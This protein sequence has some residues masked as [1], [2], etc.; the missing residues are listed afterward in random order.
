M[1]DKVELRK[2]TI[3]EAVTRIL[4][5][6]RQGKYKIAF[7]MG[8]DSSHDGSQDDWAGATWDKSV[9]LM[10]NGWREGV[11]K[12]D[13][14]ARSKLAESLRP[15]PVWDVAGSDCDVAAYLAG[16]PECMG[17]IVRRR[18]PT[19]VV[20]IGVDRCASAY[21]RRDAI[22]RV[23]QNV[24]VLVESLRLAGSAAE[25][26]ACQ[27]VA[28]SGKT[29]DLRIRIQEAGRP[30]DISRM[31]YWLAH[32]AALRRSMFALEELEPAEVR[33]NFG[34]GGGHGY[35]YGQPVKDFAKDDFDE[36]APGAQSGQQE[37]DKWIAEVL[38][39]RLGRV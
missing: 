11:P 38:G 7:G 37:L 33:K 23:G 13:V 24:V 35:G 31:A 26:W 36:W 12:L 5:H 29:F 27:A 28:R 39:R 9:K 14:A 18:R 17:E 19:P 32:P 4:D 30:I 8:G 3:D 21:I 20:S 16:V 34:F 25:I 2:Y 6:E 1:L 22:E 10:T 15:K